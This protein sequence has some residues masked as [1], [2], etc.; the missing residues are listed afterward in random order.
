MDTDNSLV[1]KVVAGVAILAGYSVLIFVALALCG[2]PG[3]L[4]V[5]VAF[6]LG[7]TWMLIPSL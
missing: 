1:A 4:L 5:W 2:L 3:I 6:L 7:L